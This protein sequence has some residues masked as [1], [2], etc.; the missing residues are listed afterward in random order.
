AA[1]SPAKVLT[2]SLDR[3]VSAPRFSSD[4]QSI[5]FMVDDDGTQNLAQVHFGDGKQG[6]RPVSGSVFVSS[7]SVGDGS[8]GNVGPGTIAVQIATIDRPDEIYL[9]AQGKL[10]QL[11]HVNDALFS[12]L[13]LSHGEY[14]HFKSKDGTPI[15]GYLYKPLDYAPSQ[16]YPTLL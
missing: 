11:T 5:Y 3:N 6:A 10:T 9:A 4:G 7:Y 15:S 8:A 2:L 1:G 14:V 12:Q 16:K 13:K